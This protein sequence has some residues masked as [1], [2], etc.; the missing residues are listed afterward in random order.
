MTPSFLFEMGS[1]GRFPIVKY[2]L[3]WLSGSALSDFFGNFFCMCSITSQCSSFP[4]L[5]DGTYSL[6]HVGEVSWVFDT[7]WY[8]YSNTPLE[9]RGYR[10]EWWIPFHV[11][12]PTILKLT[13]FYNISFRSYGRGEVCPLLSNEVIYRHYFWPFRGPSFFKSTPRGKLLSM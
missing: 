10:R 12:H 11:L 13:N 5:E 6:Y 2:V 1:R 3:L 9:G 7:W 4:S 8:C